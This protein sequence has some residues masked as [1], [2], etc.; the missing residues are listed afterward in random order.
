MDFR[1]QIFSVM[2]MFC[3]INYVRFEWFVYLAV[4]IVDSSCVCAFVLMFLCMA[5]VVVVVCFFMFFLVFSSVYLLLSH[6]PI[7][8]SHLWLLAIFPYRCHQA[9]IRRDHMEGGRSHW[10]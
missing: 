8:P 10:C 9:V 1:L 2:F 6:P 5:D 3:L 7:S 4:S